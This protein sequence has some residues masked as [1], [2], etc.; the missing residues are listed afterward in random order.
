MLRGQS[1]PRQSEAKIALYLNFDMI[2]S[3]NFVRFVYDGDNSKFRRAN[4][5]VGPPGSDAI[6]E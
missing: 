2:G 6:E 5:A 4:A 1:L 3:P